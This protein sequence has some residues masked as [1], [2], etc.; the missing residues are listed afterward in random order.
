MGHSASHYSIISCGQYT[1]VP[2]ALIR[3][4]G[5]SVL[6]SPKAYNLEFLPSRNELQQV[7]IEMDLT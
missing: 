7:T 3:N 4:Q 6:Q 2:K 5:L 1:C